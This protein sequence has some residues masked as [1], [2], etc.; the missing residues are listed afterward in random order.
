MCGCSAVPSLAAT[1]SCCPGPVSSSTL[2][3]RARSQQNGFVCRRCG[4][5]GTGEDAGDDAEGARV[6]VGAARRGRLRR[7]LPAPAQ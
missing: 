5:C 6:D 4:M 7:H 2:F 1:Q 3:L